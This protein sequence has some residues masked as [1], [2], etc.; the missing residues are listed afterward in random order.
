ME[1]PV[2][3]RDRLDG[4]HRVDETTDRA[5]VAGP[6]SV[7]ASTV[8]YERT[9]REP[10]R[11]F[12]FASRLRIRPP[13]APNAALTALVERRARSGF[14]DRLADRDIDDVESRGDREIAIDDP[15]ASRATLSAFRGVA[16]VGS[17]GDSGGREDRSVPVEA[18]LAVWTAGEYLLGGGA[19][20]LDED[21]YP[22][23]AGPAAARRELLAIVRGIEPPESDDGGRLD[24]GEAG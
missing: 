14:R 15:R 22:P 19:Y 9:G 4:W 16:R 18:L 10:P 17:G 7:D 6:V 24:D 21:A 2:V 12:C 23:G 13:T 5:F 11:P 20:P 3:P 1:P 8:R